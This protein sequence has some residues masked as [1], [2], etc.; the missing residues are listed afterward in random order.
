[1][2]H[3]LSVYPSISHSLLFLQL[4]DR[5]STAWYFYTSK[6]SLNHFTINMYSKPYFFISGHKYAMYRVSSDP[7]VHV[8]TPDAWQASLPVT[9]S[10]L[11]LLCMSAKLR[12]QRQSRIKAKHERQNLLCLSTVLHRRY[13]IISTEEGIPRKWCHF[14]TTRLCRGFPIAG[15]CWC[16]TFHGAGS[17]VPLM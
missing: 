4:T 14:T 10:I 9:G 3:F 15:F 17:A 11:H 5:V 13:D 16:F 7:G 1:M 2:H 8:R 12:V 6:V